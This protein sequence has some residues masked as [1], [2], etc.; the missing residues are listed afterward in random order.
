MFKIKNDMKTNSSLGGYFVTV[1]KVEVARNISKAKAI[2]I[3]V[4]HYNQNPERGTLNV[5]IG[6]LK[7]IR[8]EMVYT[9]TPLSISIKAMLLSFNES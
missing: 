2:E 9:C 1:G 7:R 5:G 6:R 4:K 3:G 8:D